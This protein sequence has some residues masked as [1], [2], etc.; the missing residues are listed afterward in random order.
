MYKLKEERGNKPCG[1]PAP[2]LYPNWLEDT[3]VFEQEFKIMLSTTELSLIPRLW[4]NPK[5]EKGPELL[6]APLLRLPLTKAPPDLIPAHIV[7]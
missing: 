3:F 2:L 5:L 1:V 6:K 4:H 7:V